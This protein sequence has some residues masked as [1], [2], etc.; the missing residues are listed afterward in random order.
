[1]PGIQVFQLEIERSVD[2]DRRRFRL[3]LRRGRY[4]LLPRARAFWEESLL[5]FHRDRPERVPVVHVNALHESGEFEGIP[6]RSTAEA[7]EYPSFDVRRER[8][9]TPIAVVIRQGAETLMLHPL[10]LDLYAIVP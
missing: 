10:P 3:G 5:Q 7:V 2:Y 1:M 6:L 8:R 9:R 4:R